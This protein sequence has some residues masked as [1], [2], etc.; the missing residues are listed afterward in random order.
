MDRVPVSSS[1]IVEIGY[2]EESQT[3]EV[4]FK[5]ERVY[6]YF[7]VPGQ[8]TNDLMNA[9]SHGQYLN[10]HIKGLYRYARV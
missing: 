7:S 4:L 2:D 1:N 5:N 6:Q 8:I 9:A 3:L 10:Q